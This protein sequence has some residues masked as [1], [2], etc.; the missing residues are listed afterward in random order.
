MDAGTTP[1]TPGPVERHRRRQDGG[2]RQDR[3]AKRH[4]QVVETKH[5]HGGTAARR[6]DVPPTTPARLPPVSANP[7]GL[8]A[9][10]FAALV[11]VVAC[12]IA[13]LWYVLP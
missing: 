13:F 5:L 9:I 6:D 11:G 4:L 3:P 7:P 10:L 8:L 12:L 1:T 2:H